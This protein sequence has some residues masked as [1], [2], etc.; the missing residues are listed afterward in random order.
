MPYKRQRAHT[1]PALSY[2][3]HKGKAKDRREEL[4][5]ERGLRSPKD[6][7][8]FNH[9]FVCLAFVDCKDGTMYTDLRGK[10]PMK[11]LRGQRPTSSSVTGRA[12]LSLP[13]PSITTQRSGLWEYLK[14]MWSV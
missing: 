3:F 14:Q 9:L 12:T 8:K 1:P 2:P 6:N 7:E 4:E 10:F 11:V 13:R 5:V